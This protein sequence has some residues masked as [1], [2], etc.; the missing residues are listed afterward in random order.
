MRPGAVGVEVC[1]HKAGAFRGATTSAPFLISASNCLA[2][3][4]RQFGTYAPPAC[5]RKARKVSAAGLLQGLYGT[6]AMPSYDHPRLSRPGCRW[7]VS[8]GKLEDVTPAI[9]AAFICVRWNTSP[10][11]T[12]VEWR[13]R[14]SAGH[15][16]TSWCRM[17]AAP[18]LLGTC[19]NRLQTR[20]EEVSS[21]QPWSGP[22]AGSPRTGLPCG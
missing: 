13:K 17:H 11:T 22:Q 19:E 18:G 12:V 20:P 5:S 6:T 7:C 14:S 9:I 1:A 10:S 2:A 8:F 16:Q 4:A 3:E 21:V 15:P